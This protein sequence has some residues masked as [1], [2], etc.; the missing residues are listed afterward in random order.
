M[1][2]LVISGGI[3]I[4]GTGG[5]RIRT[6]VHAHGM[7]IRAH[8]MHDLTRVSGQLV[9]STPQARTLRRGLGA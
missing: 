2:Q 7:P 4:D 5:P 6:N 9:R 3:A 8:G 1:R